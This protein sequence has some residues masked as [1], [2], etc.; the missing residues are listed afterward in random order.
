MLT[1]VQFHYRLTYT[2]DLCLGLFIKDGESERLIGHVIANRASG[3]Y[4]TDGSM[5]M[6]ENWQTLS[7]DEAVIID[8]QVVGNDPKGST[9]TIHSVVII[10]EFQGKGVGKALVDAYI[11]YIKDAKIPAKRLAMI[12]HGHLIKFYESSGFEKQGLSKC[13]FAGGGWYDLVMLSNNDCFFG[14]Y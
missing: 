9:V 6:P 1:K 7:G 11:Q 10:P 14:V 12:A 13:Q 2:P 3:E 4:V 5:M 8:G